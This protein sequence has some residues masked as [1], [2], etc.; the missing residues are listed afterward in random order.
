MAKNIKAKDL[1]KSHELVLEVPELTI[2]SF[3][4]GF[5]TV[6]ADKFTADKIT[7]IRANTY[8]KNSTQL[9]YFDEGT[10]TEKPIVVPNSFLFK[11]ADK[12]TTQK[13]MDTFKKWM[14][15]NLSQHCR[16]L[17][18]SIGS[19]PEIFVEN[20]KG[21]L[22]PA[23]DFLGSKS[24]R[25]LVQSP[26]HGVISNNTYWD[27]FQAEFETAAN[28]CMQIHG[29][30]IRYGLI[31]TLTAARKKDPAAKL[32]IKTVMDISP[33]LLRNS[34]PEYVAFGCRASLNAYGMQ[35]RQAPGEEVT[36]RSAG[37]HIHFG[38]TDKLKEDKAGIVKMVKALDAVLGVA[39]VSLFAKFD[40]PR[41]RQMYG[42]AGEYRL[43]PHGLEYR[44]LSN[45]WL[46]HPMI[47]H[48]VFD[49]A[50]SVTTFGYKDF[51]KYWDC[52]EK[53]TIRIIN[54]CDVPAARKV[55]KKNKKIL[56]Q[57]I[58]TRY[59]NMD[60][61]EFVYDIL[62]HGMETVIREPGNLEYNWQM[63][64]DPKQNHNWGNFKSIYVRDAMK[65]ADKV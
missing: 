1:W 17:G 55:L 19:D 6:P 16:Y 65:A 40:D 64:L 46:F 35:G 28:T 11:A 44:T 10:K 38:L 51:L 53:E 29:G 47:A 32:S 63:G 37:G 62:C 58:N 31:A 54:E 3:I 27:G 24:D 8:T 13:L 20:N 34:K 50:R 52:E 33:E 59:N 43:P 14:L 7:V 61:A 57:I 30:S 22:F 15:E 2:K 60:Q 18:Q 25:N 45:A 48:L 5:N 4:D 12:E 41:R 23:F 9:F 42:L 56:L 21:E 49:L 39:C 36:F 26:I